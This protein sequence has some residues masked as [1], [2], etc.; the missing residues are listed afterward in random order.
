MRS[1][2]RIEQAI[3]QPVLVQVEAPVDELPGPGA[4][5]QAAI[6]ESMPQLLETSEIGRSD[7]FHERPIGG[8]IAGQLLEPWALD[9]F[10]LDKFSGH[11]AKEPGRGING[12]PQKQAAPAAGD[13]HPIPFPDNPAFAGDQLPAIRIDPDAVASKLR[14]EGMPRFWAAVTT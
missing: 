12:L 4:L 8:V 2:R 10:E 7:L 11:E 1:E 3:D 9:G 13:G 14:S 6:A 5:T